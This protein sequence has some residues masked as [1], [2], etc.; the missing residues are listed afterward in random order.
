M[1]Q[2]T[3]LHL[4]APDLTYRL[5]AEHRAQVRP[6]FDPDA[7]ERLL[8]RAL[9]EIRPYLEKSLFRHPQAQEWSQVSRINDP[10][11]QALLDEA[12]QPFWA[13]YAI[14]VLKDES[15]DG[16]PGRRLALERRRRSRGA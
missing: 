1:N 16:Y 10:V 14:Q 2:G 6:P 3:P 9:P 12:W 8:Q 4:D 15:M 7:L 5:D 11:L 13:D